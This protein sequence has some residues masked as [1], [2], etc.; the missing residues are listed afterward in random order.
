LY[1]KK[2]ILL[3]VLSIA[4]LSCKKSDEDLK[5]DLNKNILTALKTHLT[6]RA[7]E[8]NVN[9]DDV[10]L[11]EVDTLTDLM[12][13]KGQEEYLNLDIDLVMNKIDIER[14]KRLL[15]SEIGVY[16]S[17]NMKK[18]ANIEIQQS[19]DELKELKKKQEALDLQFANKPDSL[20]FRGYLELKSF[21]EL[22]R[23]LNKH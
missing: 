15:E 6:V 18:L 22:L 5:T 21:M 1:E 4:F 17:E 23:K 14:Q 9:L 20:T 16:D 11:I 10:A 13:L 8:K 12:I 19:I 7:K 2:I 3:T